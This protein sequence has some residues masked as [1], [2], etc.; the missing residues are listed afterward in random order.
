MLYGE[1]NRY[2]IKLTIQARMINYWNRLVVADRNKYSSFV[3]RAMTYGNHRFKWMESIRT[4][5]NNT[6]YS[7]ILENQ[8]QIEPKNTSK[9]VKRSLIDQFIQTW[10]SSMS[11]TNKGRNYKIFKSEFKYEN[12]LTKL[13]IQEALNL[14][15]LRTCN[16]RFPIEVG[17]WFNT[18]YHERYC[19]LCNSTDLGDTFHYLF[20]CTKFTDFRD[21]FISRY[22][23]VNPN[24][25]K[26]IQLMQTNN[27]TV[28]KN[29]S[30]FTINIIKNMT[31]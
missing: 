31:S 22:Y 7:Y 11:N 26:F 27:T 17:R 5:F 3:Y 6:G 2:P 30:N 21:K 23:R 4:I 13:P 24:M 1:L 16:T 9:I 12:Y 10:N 25:L 8:F 18:P 20:K 28:L 29:L 14:F 19:H 15:K